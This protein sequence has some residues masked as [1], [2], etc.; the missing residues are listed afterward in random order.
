MNRRIKKKF[1]F[2]SQIQDESGAVVVLVA[3]MLTV[4]LMFTALAVDFGLLY[5][6]ESKLQTAC[7]AASL[8][9]AQVYKPGDCSSETVARTKAKEIMKANGYDIEDSDVKFDAT[10]QSVEVTKKI[11]VKTSF[12]SVMNIQYM[13]AEKSA[14]AAVVS[15]PATGGGEYAIFSGSTTKPLAIGGSLHCSSD[16]GVHTNMNIV[17]GSSGPSFRAEGDVTSLGVSD[18]GNAHQFSMNGTDEMSTDGEATILTEPIA[19]PQYDDAVMNRIPNKNVVTKNTVYEN[20]EDYAE[21]NIDGYVSG[22]PI[23]VNENIKVKRISKNVS[24]KAYTNVKDEVVTESVSEL[25]TILTINGSIEVVGDNSLAIPQREIISGTMNTINNDASLY[26][27]QGNLSVVGYTTMQAG[28]VVAEGDIDITASFG[29][30]GMN[31]N[32]A[33]AIYS[34]NGDINFCPGSNWRFF[35]LIYAPCGEVYV[36]RFAVEVHGSV[37]ADTIDIQAN[38]ADPSRS[39]SIAVRSW[40]AS[41]QFVPNISSTPDDSGNS[42]VPTGKVKLVK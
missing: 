33:A 12:A 2:K 22:A 19:M 23:A 29:L 14:K 10:E 41:D 1:S 25:N 6:Q 35:G 32:R 4:L 28:Y 36:K 15:K 5:L 37:V 3:L 40:S 39:G 30:Y 16:L 17:M 24:V 9:A 8:A 18:K 21:Q 27:K 31:M 38:S 7:D 34:K 42:G 20:L 13:K 11:D 26:V